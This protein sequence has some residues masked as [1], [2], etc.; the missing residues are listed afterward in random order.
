MTREEA[1]TALGLEGDATQDEITAAY[2]ELA[3]M[4]HPD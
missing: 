2:R 3:Q 4:L 1:L